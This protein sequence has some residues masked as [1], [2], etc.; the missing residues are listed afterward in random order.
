ML[1]LLYTFNLRTSIKSVHY[2][3]PERNSTS[4][5]LFKYCLYKVFKG[6]G[7]K[8]LFTKQKSDVENFTITRGDRG[9]G[10]TGRLILAYTHLDMTERLHFYFA[11]SCIGEANGTPLRYSC[12]KNPRDGGARWAAIYGVAQRPTRLK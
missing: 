10:Y 11:L 1:F 7:D 2:R 3:N 5:K 12:L 8:W 4:Y 9:Q 6:E